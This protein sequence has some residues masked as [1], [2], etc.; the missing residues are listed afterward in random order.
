MAKQIE[1]GK[2]N[3]NLKVWSNTQKQT[4][5]DSNRIFLIQ[6]NVSLVLTRE[7]L[8][9]QNLLSDGFLVDSTKFH[10]NQE[11]FDLMS[12]RKFFWFNQ[13]L[14]NIKEKDFL[15]Q[16]HFFWVKAEAPTLIE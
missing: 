8:F 7:K 4:F 2:F 14:M 3:K 9:N 1:K 6:K 10:L 16:E 5:F 13:S 12:Q 11:I 15:F